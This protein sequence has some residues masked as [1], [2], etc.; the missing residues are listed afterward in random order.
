MDVHPFPHSKQPPSFTGALGRIQIQVKLLSSGSVQVGDRLLLQIRISDV[1]PLDEFTLPSLGCQPGFSGFFEMSDLPPQAEVRGTE[2][3]FQIECRVLT[4]LV[5]QIPSIEV[6]SFDPEKGDYS[7]ARTAPLPFLL[8]SSPS[9]SLHSS[10]LEKPFPLPSFETW[11]TPPL[12]PLK[13]PIDPVKETGELFE[14][15]NALYEKGGRATTFEERKGL[16]NQAL[17]LYH[18][19]TKERESS[20]LYRGLGDTYFQLGELPWALLFYERALKSNPASS[21]ALSHLKKAQEALG[22]PLFLPA[23]SFLSF[24]LLSFFIVFVAVFL[25]LYFLI[26]RKFS[27]TGMI[28]FAFFIFFLL[29]S[30][31]STP[32]EGILVEPTGL[33]RTPD[34]QQPQLTSSPLMAGSKVNVLQIIQGGSW[35]KIRSQEG[36]IGYILAEPIRVI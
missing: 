34:R 19:A 35:L 5:D 28:L 30:D 9:L 36:K 4:S 22:L 2:K 25:V 14:K 23:S 32:I 29:V 24:S 7:I 3:I 17:Q 10:P 31:F 1:H 8:S 15:A 12:P 16:F 11:P 27:K 13:L 18:L 33:Y 6:A 21:L 20:D 26:F